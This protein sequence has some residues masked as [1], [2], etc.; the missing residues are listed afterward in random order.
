MNLYKCDICGDV[1]D[2]FEY[3][4]RKRINRMVI[5]YYP[6]WG[7]YNDTFDICPNCKAAI[8]RF[9]EKRRKLNESNC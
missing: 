8:E 3:C 6:D 7:V 2:S 1:F 5:T 4:N 9:I